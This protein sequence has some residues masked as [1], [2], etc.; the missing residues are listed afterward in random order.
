M[1][2]KNLLAIYLNEFNINFLKS[3]A[4]K[5]RCQNIK[6]FLSL[7]KCKTYSPDKVQDKN[8]D[9]WVQS[10]SISTGKRSSEHKIFKIGQKKTSTNIQIWDCL[11]KKNISCGVWGAMNSKFNDNK[12][13]RVYFPDPWNNFDIPFPKNLIYLFKLPR[14]YAQNYTNFKIY[15]NFKSILLF[16]FGIFKFGV[17]N[18]LIK[19]FFFY[20]NIFFNTGIKNYFLFFLLDIFSI[21]VYEKISKKNNLHFSLIFLNS[22]AHYQH[23]NWDEGKN[24]W[25]FFLL[26]DEMF[27]IINKIY[28]NYNSLIIFNGFTQKKIKP[29]FIIRANDFGKFFK[30]LNIKYKSIL[31]NMTNG[32]FISFNKIL[33]KKNAIK[34]LKNFN[35]FGLNVFEIKSTDKLVFFFRIQIKSFSNLKNF[36]KKINY[37]NHKKYLSYENK[38]S[39]YLIRKKNNDLFWFVSRVTFIKTT[40]KH[41][42]EGDLIFKNINV[43]KN[44]IENKE[45]FNIIQRHF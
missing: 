28:L 36:Y 30:D 18:Y 14:S 19:N 10:V 20:L 9:P 24:H 34:I 21:V 37:K 23:N 44:K 1:S 40:G 42:S 12:N 27:R 8:L 32:G 25:K 6:N 5:F 13:L 2:K 39:K 15:S 35:L 4:K 45:I 38:F 26:A 31:P 16:I 3:G 22:I 43:D 33:D 17:F 11:T 41:I 29:E 7:Q